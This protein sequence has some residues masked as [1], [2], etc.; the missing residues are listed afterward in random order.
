M[1]KLSAD[2]MLR[3][4]DFRRFWLT[5]TIASF[6]EQISSLAIPLT[7]VL[8]LHA[9]PAQMGTLIALQT[10]PFAL[11]SLPAGVWL[12]RRSK[13]PVLLW[14]E[15][16][17][18]CVLVMIPISYWLGLLSMH[19]LY[20]VGFLMGVG[21]V[22]GGSAAQVFLAQLVGREH[23]LDAQ[24]KF[25]ATDSM[26]RLIGPGIAGMLVQLLTAPVAVLVNAL[27]FLSSWWNLRY[28]R[29][30]DPYPA[31]SNR[32]PFREM[33]DGIKMV[34]NHE[35]LWALAWGTALWQIL[36]NGYL[37][38]Q[39]LFATRQ[40]GMSPGVLGAAQTLGG[41]GVLV[42]SM[43]LK[44]LSR[45]FGSGRTILIGLGG[46]AAAWLLLAAIPPTI[47]GSSLLSALAYGVVVFVFDCSAMLYF[48]PYLAL[49]LKL[50]PDAFHGRMV[51][52]MRFM[53]VAAAPL[54]A[55][56]AGWIAEHLGVRSG[57][58]AIAAGGSLLTFGL[59]KASPLRDI[60]D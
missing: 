43:L 45:R 22:V 8:L 1:R 15:F 18:G 59:I 35:V 52:T 56:S 21:F 57:L 32:H 54:G 36:F 16:L 48:M 5:T 6:G 24:S 42:S 37:A 30:R 44:P 14:S 19:V 47:F 17:F 9:T 51:S 46:T 34:R 58:I 55:L 12:D 11:F 40:L 38:L 49:R 31:P 26:A 7:A 33:V 53:T 2:P 60:R 50:T 23:L 41:F 25:A 3:H 10:L 4:H 39:I 29:K 27:S 13:Y 20:T 28:L